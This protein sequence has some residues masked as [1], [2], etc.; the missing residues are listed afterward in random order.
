[1]TTVTGTGVDGRCYGRNNQGFVRY[2]GGHRT[3]G[4]VSYKKEIG[5]SYR[6]GR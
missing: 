5:N 6:V 1:M 4:D 3:Q 2:E